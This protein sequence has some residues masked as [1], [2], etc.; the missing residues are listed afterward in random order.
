MTICNR[1]AKYSDGSV[2]I[3]AVECYDK[4]SNVPWY[5]I[6]VSD[7]M[8]ICDTYKTARTTWKRKF[9]SVVLEKTGK[10]I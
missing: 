9:K 1:L 5:E 2:T 8:W 4:Y 7:G 10:H 3:T 6:N